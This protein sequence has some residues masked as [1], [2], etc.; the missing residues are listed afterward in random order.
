[1]VIFPEEEGGRTGIAESIEKPRQNTVKPVVLAEPP[2]PMI[3][4][5][6]IKKIRKKQMQQ[7]KASQ[8]G[9]AQFQVPRQPTTDMPQE[10][11]H[12]NAFHEMMGGGEKI[13]GWKN[14]PVYINETL[15]SGEGLI[16]GTQRISDNDT[17]R[18]TARMFG[19]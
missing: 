18:R 19:F 10:G 11:W 4:K 2:A 3:S 14:E 6:K 5:K 16:K 1:M 7:V 12:Q 13:W 9:L 17:E 15:T 8:R